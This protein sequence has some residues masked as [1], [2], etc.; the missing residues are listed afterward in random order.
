MRVIRHVEH[1]RVFHRP[2]ALLFALRA[3]HQHRML[4]VD[5]SRNLSIPSSAKNGR[6]ASI[7]IHAS[8]VVRRQW[9]ATVFIMDRFRIVQEESAFSLVESPLLAAQDEGAEFEGGSPRPGRMAAGRF[10]DDG[11]QNPTDHPLVR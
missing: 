4:L 3:V 1:A 9:K 7:R 11:S 6:G 5:A 8:E 2:H 10:Q